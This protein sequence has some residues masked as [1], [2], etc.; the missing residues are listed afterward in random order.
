MDGR[1]GTCGGEAKTHTS[2]KELQWVGSCGEPWSP[3]IWRDTVHRISEF[4]GVPTIVTMCQAEP[5]LVNNN[6]I[7]ANTQ[8][9]FF[10]FYRN[11]NKTIDEMEIFLN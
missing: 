11:I 8:A 10:F 2:Y 9:V 6:C 7:I 4:Y 5:H 1:T 3:K